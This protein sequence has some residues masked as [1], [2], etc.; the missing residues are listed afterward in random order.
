M[1]I[2]LLVAAA[3]IFVSACASS[4][5]DSSFGCTPAPDEQRHSDSEFP[6]SVSTNPVT[7]GDVIV[8]YVGSNETPGPDSIVGGD[9]LTGYGS[10]WQCW[11]GTEWVDTHLL[12]HG[13]DGQGRTLEGEPGVT[14]TV[15]AI[16]LPVPFPFQI[17]V[18]EVSSG[19]YR[20]QSTIFAGDGG[21]PPQPFI[22]YVAVEVDDRG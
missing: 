12:V 14:S 7:A 16:G 19:W 17:T 4:G 3:A 9:A 15:P 1:S 10:S 2:G 8:L 13:T 20:I 22:G 5:D 21:G 6:L 11:D 18:P